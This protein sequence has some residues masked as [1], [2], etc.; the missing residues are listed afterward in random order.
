[1]SVEDHIARLE[2]HKAALLRTRSE[3]QKKIN[4]IQ[5][6]P[7]WVFWNW[8]V[9]SLCDTAFNLVMI[10]VTLELH[11]NDY[12]MAT[13]GKE[14]SCQSRGRVTSKSQP[15]LTGIFE[16]DL[17]ENLWILS[18][19]A[20]GTLLLGFR[21]STLCSAWRIHLSGMVFWIIGQLWI[22]EILRNYTQIAVSLSMYCIRRRTSSS[23]SFAASCWFR[24]QSASKITFLLPDLH[25]S[26]KNEFERLPDSPLHP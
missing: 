6:R 22:T 2:D 20:S 12:S 9:V 11:H 25:R 23:F 26:V 3:I 1:M 19:I 8:W 16:Q 17:P 15:W 24:T 7:S 14:G 10:S 18:A 13:F 21:N 5:S 4:E